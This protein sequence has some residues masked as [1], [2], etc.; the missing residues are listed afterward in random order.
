MP[1]KI[2]RFIKKL[3]YE[4]FDDNLFNGAAALAYYMTLSL[5]PAT[6]F[7]LTLL[8]Y[9]PIPHLDNQVM[10]LLQQAMPPQAADM[11]SG[12]VG[13]VT[14]Q[15]KGGLLTFGILF[16][17]W[18]ASTGINAVLQELNTTYDVKEERPFYKVRGIALLLLLAFVV[19]IVGAFGL[20]VTGGFIQGLFAQWF[21]Q[22]HW[23]LLFFA[24]IRW[25]VIALFLLLGFALTYYFGPDVEQEFR[26]ITPGSLIGVILL[27]LSSLLFSW[28]ISNFADYSA[29]YGSIGAVIVLMLWLY[30][31]G[32]VILLGSEINA[33]I[34]FNSP[35]AKS[36]GDKKISSHKP[37]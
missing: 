1:G 26:F 30:I 10:A 8:P 33:L 17:I 6:I 23:L 24:V 4:I 35:R 29:T 25:L 18:S 14:R 19:L 2:W 5:F 28:Y 15:K 31:T 16:T 32:F 7:L 9:L 20:I 27:A 3:W 22:S 13:E 12:V 21:G 37:G 34:E 11:F 36:R